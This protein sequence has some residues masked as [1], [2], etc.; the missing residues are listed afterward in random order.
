MGD[1]REVHRRSVKGRDIR[2]R[3]SIYYIKWTRDEENK[4]IIRW[5]RG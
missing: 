1:G 2:V 4:E 5:K 3:E